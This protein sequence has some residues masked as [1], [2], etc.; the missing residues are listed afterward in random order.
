MQDPLGSHLERCR[1]AAGL[2][3]GQLALRAGW[4][5]ASRG[6]ARV[7]ELEL[8]GEA[9][10][11]TLRRVVRALGVQADTVLALRQ[12]S[13][14]LRRQAWQRWADEPVPVSVAMR[15]FAG[16]MLGVQV[17][18]ARQQPAA[19]QAWVTQAALRTGCLHC[20]AWSR[21]RCT[22]VRGDGSSYEVQASF[23]APEVGMGMGLA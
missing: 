11:E 16:C 6:G 7:R 2:T 5:D 8:T 4:S 3:P 17:P 9:S 21:R 13:L 19:L 1:L 15:A 20:I 23:E 12:R 14:D 10:Q 18:E 22:Y